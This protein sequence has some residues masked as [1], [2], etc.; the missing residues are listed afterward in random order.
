M[1][2]ITKLKKGRK[3]GQQWQIIVIHFTGINEVVIV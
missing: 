1:I 3:G 2:N